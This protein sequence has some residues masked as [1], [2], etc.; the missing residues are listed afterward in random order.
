MQTLIQSPDLVHQALLPVN[1]IT[2]SAT[3]PR[4]RIADEMIAELA[5]SVAKVGVLQPILVR[6]CTGTWMKYEIVAGE[7]R[8]RAAVK[9]GLETIPATIRDLTD[10]EALELQVLEN[11]HRN[12]LHPMEEAEGF[13]QLLDANGYTAATLASKIGKSKAYVYASLKLCEL[14]QAGR[15][16]FFEGKLTASTALLIARIPGEKL[17]MEAVKT[18]T[19]PNYSGE[20]PSYRAAAET[21]QRR[22][23]TN[24]ENAIFDETDPD[25]VPDAGSCIDCPKLSGNSRE[26]FPD[27]KSADV[28][29]DT[30]CFQAKRQAHIAHLKTLP[31]TIQGEAAIE[32]LPNRWSQPLSP[33]YK[34]PYSKPEGAKESWESLLGDELPTRTVI[35]DDESDPVVL[36]DVV[37]AHKLLDEKGIQLEPEKERE[38]S[39]YEIERTERRIAQEAEAKRRVALLAALHQQLASGDVLRKILR[40]TLPMVIVNLFEQFDV[41]DAMQFFSARGEKDWLFTLD[42]TE[43]EGLISEMFQKDQERLLIELF[44]VTADRNGGLIPGFYWKPGETEGLDTFNAILSVAGID[45]DSNPGETPTDSASAAHAEEEVA[46]AGKPDAAKTAAHAGEPDGEDQGPTPIQAASAASKRAAKKPAAKTAAEA[47]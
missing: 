41:Q 6:P 14:C 46:C 32:L 12:D 40:A 19:V 34:L 39:P 36:V 23:T 5:A 43:W 4:K 27:I 21:I 10:I 33:D 29:T 8:Y 20:L 2:P 16:A 3:N 13:R 44:A 9:A 45:P 28:C 22:F 47:V 1:E 30:V 42:E 17:Q 38:L 11:L 15:E 37:A 7:C 35:R 31:D 26:I 24:L 18:I 25:L